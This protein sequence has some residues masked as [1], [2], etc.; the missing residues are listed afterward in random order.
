METLAT[1]PTVIST[2]EGGMVSA[3]TPEAASSAT[4]AGRGRC[5]A[6]RIFRQQ[7]RGDGGHVGDL[8]AGDAGH[9]E[10]GADEHVLQAAANMAE[11]GWR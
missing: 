7:R 2:S 10:D 5:R 11:Q 4:M 8:G 9:Q 1:A 6:W 3:M